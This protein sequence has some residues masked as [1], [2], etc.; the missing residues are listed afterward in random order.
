[1]KHIH[2]WILRIDNAA[3]W[4]CGISFIGYKLTD[5]DLF[6]SLIMVSGLVSIVCGIYFIIREIII[7]R[8]IKAFIKKFWLELFFFLMIVLMMATIV[9]GVSLK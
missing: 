2:K 5:S 3:M 6:H 9:I 8:S 1:M 7:A 4:V